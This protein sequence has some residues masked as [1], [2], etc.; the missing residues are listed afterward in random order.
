MAALE[1]KQ[2]AKEAKERERQQV[3]MAKLAEKW[4]ALSESDRKPFAEKAAKLKVRRRRA[5]PCAPPRS[6]R[7]KLRKL[8][9]RLSGERRVTRAM[10]SL[11]KCKKTMLARK[12]RICG[13][14]RR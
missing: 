4:R 1:A 2:A 3:L 7:V 8:R 6:A 13:S 9:P 12:K 11:S 5:L 10:L 14:D